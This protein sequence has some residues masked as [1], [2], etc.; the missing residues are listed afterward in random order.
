MLLKQS[1]SDE[2]KL[3]KF[4][5]SSHTSLTPEPSSWTGFAIVGREEA[6][7]FWIS[8]SSSLSQSM[9]WLPS[10]AALPA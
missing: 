4:K 9:L 3:H 7:E 5:M 8:K 2:K 6:H 1:I 10:S